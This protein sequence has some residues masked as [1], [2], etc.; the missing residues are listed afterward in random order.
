[1]SEAQTPNDVPSVDKN[2]DKSKDSKLNCELIEDKPFE[3]TIDAAFEILELS[4]FKGE[5][6]INNNH[7]QELYDEM[8]AGR[9]R[10]EHVRLAL[11]KLGDKTYRINGGHTCW[12]RT[13]MPP[14]YS[15][16]V[17]RLIYKVPND[18]ELK[19]LYAVFDPSYS[20]RG[21]RHLTQIMLLDTTA[22]AGF[23]PSIIGHLANGFKYW[24]YGENRTEYRRIGH[25]ELSE[26]IKKHVPLFQAIGAFWPPFVRVPHIGH[27]QGVLAAMFECYDRRPTMFEEFWKPVCDQLGLTEKTD[28]RHALMTWLQQHMLDIAPGQK[29][30]KITNTE[31]MYLVCVNAWNRWRAKDLVTGPL[32]GTS[33]RVH[34]K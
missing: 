21:S 3:L 20:A 16:I 11:C 24:K 9:F 26:E 33:S 27:R 25:N 5:R 1:M 14:G 34:A 23:S 32:R 12:A 17:R 13:N 8:A 2:Y 29:K 18:A 7:V 31:E 6:P 19:K 4:E 30:G 28:A 22:G 15:C 10:P